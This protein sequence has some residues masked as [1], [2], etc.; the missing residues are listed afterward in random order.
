M[1]TTKVAITSNFKDKDID[2]YDLC[3][4][5]KRPKEMG[6]VIR[7]CQVCSTIGCNKCLFPFP[8]LSLCETCH[9]ETVKYAQGILDKKPPVEVILDKMKPLV[10]H[11]KRR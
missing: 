4:T 8:E 5:C 1:R 11:M 3:P 10:K 9:K 7:K 2:N 6:V